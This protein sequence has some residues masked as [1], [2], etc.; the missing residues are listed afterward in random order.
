[1]L[2]TNEQWVPMSYENVNEDGTLLL[3]NPE[4]TSSQPK[5][6]LSKVW[7]METEQQHHESKARFLGIRHNSRS[8]T[9]VELALGHYLA[10]AG[11][12]RKTLDWLNILIS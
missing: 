2:A 7:G 11:S 12:D 5:S 8:L 4:L 3:M 10:C 1:M 9:V 6:M